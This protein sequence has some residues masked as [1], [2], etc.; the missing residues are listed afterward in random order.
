MDK[1]S[2]FFCDPAKVIKSVAVAFICLGILVY[3]ISQAVGSAGNG[4]ETETSMLVTLNDSIEADAYIFRDETVVNKG[5]DGAIVTVV[6]E[7]DR[8]S[9]GQLIANVYPDSADAL[10]QD[11]INRVQRRIDILED[12]AVD[13]KFVV[14]DLTQ[15]DADINTVL[16][17]ICRSSSSGKLSKAVSSS[18]DF[19]VKLNKRD[20]IVDSD[21]D[22][23]SELS[24]LTDEKKHLESQI[25]SISTPVYASS[26]GYFY[27][28]VDG[29]E[30]T[31]K[32]TDVNK[33]TL[34]NFEKY[35]QAVP[36]ESLLGKGSVKI[37]NNFIWY[38]VCV[39]D[40]EYLAELNLGYSYT[41][42][43]PE[44]A[45]AEIDMVL[46]KIVSE[47][48]STT[49]I[50]IFRVNKLP[51]DFGYNRFQRCEIVKKN[52]EGLS[53]PKKA[54]RVIDG[55]EGVYI[56]VGDVVRFRRVERIAEKDGYYVVKYKKGTTMFDA[57]E[58]DE[59][60]QN[61]EPLGLYDNIIISGKDLFDGKIV[62]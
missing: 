14:S 24:R 28:D 34:D 33:I 48:N 30:N 8:V 36:D 31:F 2:R 16:T 23:T 18:S 26:A 20:L 32:V 9:K 38:L 46:H 58:V 3:V 21:F 57:E 60:L 19:L 27:G 50:C 47:T 53:V 54:L 5:Y 25:T 56:L 62:G 42:S 15:I 37:V 41:M 49:A 59:K 10:L 35:A 44:N 1:F 52:V 7:G 4:I 51:S 13:S 40:S 17:D 6:S 45:D 29:Y 39:I 11:E 43:F 55:V 61:I 12:S 22:Y